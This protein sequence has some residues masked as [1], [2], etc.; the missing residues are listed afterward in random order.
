MAI[1]NLLQDLNWGALPGSS[2]GVVL[3]ATSGTLSTA[4]GGHAILNA[5]G[6]PT[7]QTVAANKQGMSCAIHDVYTG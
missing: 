6:V 1:Y 4:I 7:S 3:D 2:G 5:L